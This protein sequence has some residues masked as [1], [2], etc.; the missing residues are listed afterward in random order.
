MYIV[1]TKLSH[2]P[3]I[4]ISESCKLHH[5]A[6]DTA[7]IWKPPIWKLCST[8]L[9]EL[10]STTHKTTLTNV[11]LMRAWSLS[12]LKTSLLY[13]PCSRVMLPLDTNLYWYNPC[14]LCW[15]GTIFDTSWLLPRTTY[16]TQAHVPKWEMNSQVV[17]CIRP[18]NYVSPDL[19]SPSLCRYL[20]LQQI[21]LLGEE[22]VPVI[23]RSYMQS[24]IGRLSHMGKVVPLGKTFSTSFKRGM[25]ELSSKLAKCCNKIRHLLVAH[26]FAVM[27]W[28]LY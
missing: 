12:Y 27:E 21:T 23:R 25:Q 10:I 19:R 20:D 7:P 15:N 28:H 6:V 18:D 26:I 2:D 13:K 14:T 22:G 4:L 24:F 9:V 3:S 17:F 16:V 1:Y 11:S 5:A 8:C